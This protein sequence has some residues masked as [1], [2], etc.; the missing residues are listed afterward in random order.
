M[1][2]IPP[3]VGHERQVIAAAGQTDISAGDTCFF[4]RLQVGKYAFFGNG[5]VNP[6]PIAPY[7]LVFGR[8]DELALK[9]DLLLLLRLLPARL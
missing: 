2:Q 5:L 3:L 1:N 4:H 8:I 7:P 6:V 9:S